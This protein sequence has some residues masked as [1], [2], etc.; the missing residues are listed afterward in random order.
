MTVVIVDYGV[1]NLFSIRQACR[2]VG[3][4][5][6]TSSDPQDIEN[7]SAVI[8]PGVGAFGHAV[9]VLH[10]KNIFQA[11]QNF[12]TLEK[13]L[14]GICLGMQLLFDESDEFG[15][16]KGLG[17]IKGKVKKLPDINERVP[18]IGWHKLHKPTDERWIA[19]TFEKLD[20]PDNDV[21]FL[22]S[23]YAEPEDDGDILS[24]T[25][26]GRHKY[27]SAVQK[28]P[29]LGCQFHPEKSG[30]NGLEIFRAFFAQF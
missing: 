11:L 14:L 12:A 21:Y 28:G 5:T 24:L 6:I 9:E 29:I 1:G 15:I 20:Y 16:H 8:L 26:W 7:A 10:E 3:V 22:H 25:N 17:I 2:H 18:R 23:Y 19:S 4:E 13:P 30:A 27:C